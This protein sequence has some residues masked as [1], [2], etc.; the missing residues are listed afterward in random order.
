MVVTNISYTSADLDRIGQRLHYTAWLLVATTF[1]TIFIVIKYSNKTMG[2]YK[3]FILLTIIAPALMDFHVTAIF[4]VLS[5]LPIA[6][7][8]GAGLVTRHL[9]PY[10]GEAYPFVRIKR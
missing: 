8:C 6:G 1:F 4:G 7:L 5:T 2:N 10:W 3:F 9:D